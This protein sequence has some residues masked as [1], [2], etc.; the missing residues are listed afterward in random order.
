MKAKIKRLIITIVLIL[1]GLIV[2]EI[3]TV[4]YRFSKPKE[5]K[6]IQTKAKTQLPR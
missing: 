3:V 1:L 6:L 2:V 5:S 4:K